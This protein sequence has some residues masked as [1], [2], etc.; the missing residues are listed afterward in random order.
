LVCD[1][2][3]LTVRRAAD[4]NLLMGRSRRAA[5]AADA[6]SMIK[7]AHYAICC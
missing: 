6:Q 3:P 2:R 4:D 7:S 1:K 5:A